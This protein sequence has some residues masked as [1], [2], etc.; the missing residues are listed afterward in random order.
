MRPSTTYT[1]F[2]AKLLLLFTVVPLCELYLL[3]LIDDLIGLWS[4][5]AIVLTTGVV[6]AILAKAEGMRVIR[7]WQKSLV[8]GKVPEEG[9]LGGVLI[10]VGGVLLVTPGVVTD[11]VGILLLIPPSRRFIAD[12][13]RRR[14][15]QRIQD[16]SIK[17][18]QVSSFDGASTEYQD[19]M[20]YRPQNVVM[21]GVGEP[22]DPSE[23]EDDDAEDPRDRRVLH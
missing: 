23:D 13:I 10:L 6:G 20:S 8:R 16:G 4:T 9:V 3:L 17:V 2:V 22:I 5:V 19:R 14:L 12:V 21:D 7:Q 11:L 15:E 18:V 1:V